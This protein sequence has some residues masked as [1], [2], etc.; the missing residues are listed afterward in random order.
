MPKIHRIIHGRMKHA[1]RR[2]VLEKK[3][4]RKWEDLVGYNA[5]DLA[6]HLESLFK[7]GMSFSNYGKWHI[8][9]IIP[10]SVFRFTMYSDAE[11][12]ICWSLKNLQPLWASENIAKSGSQKLTKKQYL[13]VRQKIES[14]E[15]II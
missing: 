11:F 3:S 6:N 5:S 15:N 7:E 13:E 9:H 10:V 14:W 2:M 4:N 12:K 1:V 8:D